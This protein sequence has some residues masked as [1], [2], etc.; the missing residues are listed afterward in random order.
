MPN[1]KY[2]PTIPGRALNKSKQ[3]AEELKNV[4]EAIKDMAENYK[5][6][7]EKD[8]ENLEDRKNNKEIFVTELLNN[9]DPYK[10][11]ILYEDI[12]DVKGK[13]LDKIFDFMLENQ[14]INENNLIEIFKQ[15][16]SYIIGIDDRD[17]NE[18]LKEN[19]MQIVRIIN[20]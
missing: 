6:S 4:S 8:Y 7:S 18:Y 1:R 16:N 12:A 5:E 17:I 9:L 11:N 2:L 15:C 10:E 3:V 19:I 20:T 13:I 14:E